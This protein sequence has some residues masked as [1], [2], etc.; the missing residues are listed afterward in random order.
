MVNETGKVLL[1]LRMVRNMLVNLKMVIITAK[2]FIHSLMV[3]NM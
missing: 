3:I 2:V 1:H